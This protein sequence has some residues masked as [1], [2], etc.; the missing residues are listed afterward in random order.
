MAT[1]SF[2]K[3]FEIKTENE[4]KSFYKGIKKSR[5]NTYTIKSSNNSNKDE[6]DILKQI[7]YRCKN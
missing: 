6:E 7:L 4:I 1:S 5:K 2:N 3:K